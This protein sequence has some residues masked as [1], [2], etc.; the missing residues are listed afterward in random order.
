MAD[1]PDQ[2]AHRGEYRSGHDPRTLRDA[3]EHHTEALR[4]AFAGFSA[5]ELAVLDGLLDR[6][7]PTGS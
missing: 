1:Q 2:N 3:L 4:D 5:D 6:L 7:R